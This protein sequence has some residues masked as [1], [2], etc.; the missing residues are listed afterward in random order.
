MRYRFTRPLITMSM[1]LLPAVLPRESHSFVPITS[2]EDRLTTIAEGSQ[3]QPRMASFED[4]TYVVAWVHSDL[5]STSGTIYARRFD[6]AGLPLAPEFAVFTDFYIYRNYALAP[7]PDKG[8]VVVW[9]V[10]RIFGPDDLQ[11]GSDI[12]FTDQSSGYNDGVG[13]VA[14]R[15]DG[16]FLITWTVVLDDPCCTFEYDVH[17]RVFDALGSPLAP[18]FQVNVY[19]P[20][21]QAYPVATATTG[22]NFAIAWGDRQQDGTFFSVYGRLFDGD[23]NALTG[24][25]LVN[26]F[27]P[28]LQLPTSMAATPA[29][30]FAVAWRSENDNNSYLRT[31]DAA[32]EPLGG[33]VLMNIDDAG[34][35]G[36]GL[37]SI[38]ADGVVLAVWSAF[39]GVNVMYD[40]GRVF[41]RFYDASLQPLTDPFQVNGFDPD[42]K[43]AGGAFL[44]NTGNA[45]H[46]VWSIGGPHFL[47]G[48]GDGV[49]GS[50][51]CIGDGPDTDGDGTGDSCDP[52]SAGFAF[53]RADRSRFRFIND[54]F[55]GDRY[56]FSGEFIV[57]SQP[58]WDAID[59]EAL[60]RVRVEGDRQRP[61]IDADLSGTGRWATNASSSK[62]TYRDG[63]AAIDGITS[64]KLQLLR[65]DEPR[66]RV[67]IGG[68]DAHYG[69]SAN[70]ALQAVTV[71]YGDAA[72]GECVG[73]EFIESEC[74][75][76]GLGR[77]FSCGR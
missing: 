26:E 41:G 21:V 74:G 66:I 17:A 29:G 13:S 33:E 53:E 60:L 64:V 18:E 30:G 8:F 58:D 69:I 15:D 38:R 4:G 51:G 68:K 63:S 20:E 35:H 9:N 49:F 62:W 71:T 40:T 23:G 47:D 76:D 59:P 12:S 48:S 77:G 55:G 36:F 7:R 25:F 42:G 6:A 72:A 11:V 39:Y 16:R 45:F 31:F 2:S 61:L 27:A 46:V 28:G 67:K 22:G 65:G 44:P 32:A 57:D 43:F 52:C 54:L 3:T 1:L 75:F 19:E 34:A 73:V 37:L 50:L 24:E 70:E 14:V 5:D 56:A 10:A